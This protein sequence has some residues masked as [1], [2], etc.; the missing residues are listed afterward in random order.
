MPLSEGQTCLARRDLFDI[1]FQLL[2]EEEDGIPGVADA[3]TDLIPGVYEGGL[4]TWE[5]ALD[6]V[7]ELDMRQHIYQAKDASWPAGRHIAEVRCMTNLDRLWNG[8]AFVLFAPYP[9]RG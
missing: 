3:H 7:A 8:R 4:K 9:A 1:R 5:C 6:L 2:N